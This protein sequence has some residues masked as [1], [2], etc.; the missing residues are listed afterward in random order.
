[1]YY[2]QVRPAVECLTP[3][4]AQFED[5]TREDFDAVILATGYR[6]NVPKWLKVG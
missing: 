2:L 5:G 6:S 4:G 1:V 3:T